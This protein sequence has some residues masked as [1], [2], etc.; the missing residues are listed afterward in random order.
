LIADGALAGV[1]C[2]AIFAVNEEGTITY[3]EIVPEIT[4]D[5][6][7]EAALAAVK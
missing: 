7:Y 5:P 3:K 6:D 2:R 1:T 4:A